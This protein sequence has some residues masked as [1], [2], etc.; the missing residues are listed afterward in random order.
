MDGTNATRPGAY[1]LEVTWEAKPGEAEAV[2]AILARLSHL[3]RAEPGCRWF[4]AHR[5]L[6][7]DHLFFLYEL[8][9]DEAAAAAHRETTHFRDLIQSRAVPLLERRER[10][11][12]VLL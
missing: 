5:S 12:H 8:F 2:A 6:E 11:S 9:D 3:I 7:N 4:A 1:A 10:V